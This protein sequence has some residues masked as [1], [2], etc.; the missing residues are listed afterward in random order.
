MTVDLK[1]FEFVMSGLSFIAL[2]GATIKARAASDVHPNVGG[3]VATTTTD[4]QGMWSLP[5]L[6][7]GLYDIAVEYGSGLIRWYKGNSKVAVAA[8]GE[9]GL[10][11]RLTNLTTPVLPAMIERQARGT[12]GVITFATNGAKLLNYNHLRIRGMVRGSATGASGLT[13]VWVRLNGGTGNS[14]LWSMTQM[15]ATSVSCTNQGGAFA[16]AIKAGEIADGFTGA[17]TI[18]SPIEIY[19]PE[20][21]NTNFKRVLQALTSDNYTG[22]TT[23][24]NLVAGGYD[25]TAAITSIEV[26]AGAS[27]GSNLRTGS[28]L[29]LYGE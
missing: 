28:V 7:D 25:T 17:S 11:D 27:A 1:G 26:S 10:A 22:F 4:G 9:V 13:P 2:S 16:T 23:A 3:V 29:T 19:I 21:R 5:G 24:Q 8:L 20:F 6:A 14:Y 12:D 15:I 18:F